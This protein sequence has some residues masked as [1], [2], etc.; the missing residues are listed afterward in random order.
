[1]KRIFLTIITMC[2][3]CLTVL[4]ALADD[5]GDKKIKVF[6]NPVERSAIVTIE[7]P[8]NRSEMTVVVYNTVG[9]V[10]QTFKSTNHKIDFHAPDAS[11]IYLLRFMENQKAIAVEK[12][13]VKE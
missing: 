10:I 13:V 2:I 4:P 3:S 7:I 12:I 9:K 1:M 6:P 11:G 5:V 8:D